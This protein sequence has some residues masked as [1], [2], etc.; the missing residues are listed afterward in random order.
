MSY[1]DLQFQ[2][3]NNGIKTIKPSGNITLRQLIQSIIKPKPEM[4]EAFKLIQRYV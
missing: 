4:V 1:L 3:Y 2:W